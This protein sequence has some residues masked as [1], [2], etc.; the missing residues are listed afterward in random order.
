MS[1]LSSCEWDA[2]L[3]WNSYRVVA[4]EVSTLFTTYLSPLLK[5][6]CIYFSFLFPFFQ[7]KMKI[8]SFCHEYHFQSVWHIDMIKITLSVVCRSELTV[9]FLA[10]D[11]CLFTMLVLTSCLCVH[12]ISGIHTYVFVTILNHPGEIKTTS[13]WTNK[14]TSHTAL[15]LV[16]LT[17]LTGER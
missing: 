11:V 7:T 17:Y 8:L 9:A 10:M 1:K 12:V 13:K 4:V 2:N 16:Q 3:L 5:A 14:L 15:M 6:L